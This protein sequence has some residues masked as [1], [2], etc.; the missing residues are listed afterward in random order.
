MR[1]LFLLLLLLNGAMF[2]WYSRPLPQEN[3][4]LV[5]NREVRPVSPQVG[6]KLL[7]EADKPLQAAGEERESAGEARCLLLGGFDSAE[8]IRQLEQRLLSLDIAAMAVRLDV[9][10]GEDHW[11]YIPPLASR[12]AT[13]RQLQDLQ[14]RKIDAYLITEG[15][16]ANG[17]LLGVFPQLAAVAGV[18]EKVRAAGYEPQVRKLPRVYQEHWLR[19][20]E[21][22][23]R[24]LDDDLLGR[25]GRDFSNLKHRLISCAGVAQQ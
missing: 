6:I 24:L 8:R 3:T 1:W 22:S 2:F 13:L 4:E 16:L 14:A 17:I 19:V 11:V 10:Q 18:A 20:A 5:L 21:K 25:L 7:S 23:Q 15:E 12:Q 9:I